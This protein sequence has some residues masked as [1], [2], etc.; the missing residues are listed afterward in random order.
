MTPFEDLLPELAVRLP[1][2]PE[3]LALA[4]LRQAAIGF[5]H[6]THILKG[7]VDEVLTRAGEAEYELFAQES[8]VEFIMLDALH[9]NDTPL[10]ALTRDQ[11]R[12]WP[13]SMQTREGAPVGYLQLGPNTVRLLPVPA[14]VST[15]RAT[16]VLRPTRDA[17]SLP[18]GLAG[19][20]EQAIIDGATM[21]AALIPDQ[22]FSN[23]NL[24]AYYQGQFAAARQQARIEANRGSS[25]ANLSVA[26]RPLG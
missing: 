18:D 10:R 23:P 9:C 19:R 7:G 22:P 11:L 21:R 25:R 4:M 1:G 20:W 14:T 6:E 17:D 15:L 16:G 2:C 26:M 24:A 8:E 5:C 3:P 13:H 12:G